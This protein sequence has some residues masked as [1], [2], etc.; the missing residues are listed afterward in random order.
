MADI[1]RAEAA[2]L[3]PLIWLKRL[4][5]PRQDHTAVPEPDKQTEGKDAESS[6]LEEARH[7]TEEYA[8]ELREII[9]KLRE[10]MN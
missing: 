6:R 1:A 7:I 3:I 8:A 10:K 9:R 5:P 2:E 4:P